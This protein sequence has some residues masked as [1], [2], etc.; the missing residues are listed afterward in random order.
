MLWIILWRHLHASDLVHY[1]SD[2]F[3]HGFLW[4][5]CDLWYYVMFLCIDKCYWLVSPACAGLLK[6][7]GCRWHRWTSLDSGLS[8]G[9]ECLWFAY[10][11]Y[12]ICDIWLIYYDVV[13]GL[14]PCLLMDAGFWY[15][16]NETRIWN[17]RVMHDNQRY[18]GRG[19]EVALPYPTNTHVVALTVG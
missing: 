12:L 9:V 10:L 4:W 15:L 17:K 5:D 8:Q 19:V 18:W 13:Y 11:C 16:S 7:W 14:L 2:S 6:Y 3:A 1:M